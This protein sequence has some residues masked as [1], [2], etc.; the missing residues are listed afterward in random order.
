MPKD[1][2]TL[3]FI[4]ASNSYSEKDLGD[5]LTAR[6]KYHD[7]PEKFLEEVNKIFERKPKDNGLYLVAQCLNR[8][9]VYLMQGLARLEVE[10]PEGVV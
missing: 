2:V 4:S 6:N 5:I 8:N 7:E 3:R 9:A 10:V 1:S